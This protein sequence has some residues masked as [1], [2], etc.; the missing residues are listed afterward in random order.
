MSQEYPPPVIVFNIA[1]QVGAVKLTGVLSA[2]RACQIH[3]QN[4]VLFTAL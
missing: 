3:F 4:A 1:S 2:W